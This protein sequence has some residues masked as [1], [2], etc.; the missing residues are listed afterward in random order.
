MKATLLEHFEAPRNVGEVDAPD[1]EFRA[2][3][4]VCGDE[5]RVTFRLREDRIE[6]VRFRAYG[7]H[8]AIAATSLL[9]ERICGGTV[10]DALQVTPE[11]L[12]GWFVD[13]PPGRKHAVEVAVMAVRGA[14]TG[15]SGPGG[16]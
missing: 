7:C 10:T 12:A 5:V 11:M 15:R 9:T 6:D 4:P 16:S 1:A 3:N 2:E 14:L 13:L 8:A